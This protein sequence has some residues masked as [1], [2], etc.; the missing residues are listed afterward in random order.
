MH[1]K[2]LLDAI[3]NSETLFIKLIKERLGIV[4]HIYQTKELCDAILEACI[5]FNLQPYEY[6]NK[7]KTCP[8][9][10]PLLEFLVAGIT[11]GESSFFRDKYQM[12][13]IQTILLPQLIHAKETSNDLT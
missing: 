10:S 13:L 5:K 9:D 12:K 11:V 8:T 6:F 7:I 4:I 3:K 1:S 2:E